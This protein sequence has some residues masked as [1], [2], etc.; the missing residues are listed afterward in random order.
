[1]SKSVGN[2]APLHEVLE[3]YGRD[4]VVMYFASGHYRQPLA[5]GEEPLAPGRGERRAHPRRRP[6]PGRGAPRR[7][8]CGHSRERFFDALADDF[9]TP[10]A[11]AAMFEW[12]REANRRG[13]RGRR[14]RPARDARRARRSRT[15]L[16]ARR[17][18]AAR[19]TLYAMARAS[20][21]RARAER[22]FD[23]ADR[24]RAQIEALGWEVR[25]GAGGL[26]AD[27]AADS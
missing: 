20:S 25:D 22:D 27:A 21:R 14:R 23:A 4:A 8:T 10:Q 5:F 12:V 13:R 11:L 3:R 9:N 26:R 17:R 1:M 19:L 15:C 24:L 6:A 16:T 7:P 2:I 18:R